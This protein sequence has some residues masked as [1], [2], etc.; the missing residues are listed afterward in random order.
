MNFFFHLGRY[1]LMLK[2]CFVKPERFYMYWKELF[3]QMVG[4]GVGSLGIISVISLFI[5]GVTAV[6]FAYQLKDTFVPMWWIGIIVR[7]SMV[8]ELAPTVTARSN[9]SSE[10]GS[11]RISEQ[12]D[13]LEIMGVSTTGYLIGPKVLACMIV[14]PLLVIFAVFFGIYGGLFA[15]MSMEVVSSDQYVR[16][17]QDGLVT[18]NVK[19]MLMKAV[20]F[21]FINFLLPG[22]FCFRGCA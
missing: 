20:S 22:V 19:I 21:A 9:I 8:L 10:L 16:G 3:R 1:V 17:L 13:A 6:Q 2:H 4:I 18:Y 15:G 5:G 7:D 11:M 12:I 14:F